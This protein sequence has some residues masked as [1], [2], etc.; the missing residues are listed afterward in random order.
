L[1]SVKIVA[2]PEEEDSSFATLNI[3][4]SILANLVRMLDVTSG[5][6]I[7]NVRA[8]RPP[9]RDPADFGAILG[10]SRGLVSNLFPSNISG[11]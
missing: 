3:K 6:K 7:V 5:N 1:I 11:D 9:D 8:G 4:Y 2:T 10:Q